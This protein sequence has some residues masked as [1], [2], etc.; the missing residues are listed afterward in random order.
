MVDAGKEELLVA[1]G[2][3]VVVDV[4][5]SFEVISDLKYRWT[6]IWKMVVT[7]R[8]QILVWKVV[9]ICHQV[10]MAA[11]HFA[12]AVSEQQISLGLCIVHV[13]LLDNI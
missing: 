9:E 4:E 7:G 12:T 6:G 1:H 10:K 8:A 13:F 2:G 5:C 3:H 11:V